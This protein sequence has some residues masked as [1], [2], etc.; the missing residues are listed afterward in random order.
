MNRGSDPEA[1]VRAMAEQAIPSEP[2]EVLASRRERTVEALETGK[3]VTPFLS[4][5]DSVRI[6]MLD[7]EG[8]SI[9]GAIE[10]RIE[11]YAAA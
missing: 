3:P 6:E 7:R 2:R 8:R 4:F 9:F 11:R 10:Q 1:L 5:G